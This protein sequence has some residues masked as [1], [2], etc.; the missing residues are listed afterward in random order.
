MPR[1]VTRLTGAQ[2]LSV[3]ETWLR[4]HPGG[5]LPQFFAYIAGLVDAV[6]IEEFQEAIALRDQ[7][8]ADLEAALAA[9]TAARETAAATLQANIEAEA[10]ARE[11]ADAVLGAEI[12]TERS[13][14]DQHETVINNIEFLTP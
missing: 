9:E 6:S 7:R 8:I 14:V 4:E 13:R 3:W 12:A 10:Q 5:T 1:T 11:T 2:G